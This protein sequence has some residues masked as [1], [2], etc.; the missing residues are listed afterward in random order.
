MNLS[1][2]TRVV[3]GAHGIAGFCG[4]CSTMGN[5][6]DDE[7][8]S[9]NLWLAQTGLCQEAVGGKLRPVNT[10]LDLAHGLQKDI[11]HGA[12]ERKCYKEDDRK[13]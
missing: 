6:V 8:G 1:C 3:R 7:E 9:A 4:P 12:V 10:H 13:R 5:A 11:E 2:T